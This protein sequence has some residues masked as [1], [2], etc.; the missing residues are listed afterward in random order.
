M[1]FSVSSQILQDRRISY[2]V[3]DQTLRIIELHDTA[4][5]FPIG[6]PKTIVGA[7]LLD[8]VPELIG[9]ESVLDDILRGT[10]PRFELAWVNL[11]LAQDQTR[12]LTLVVL[13]NRDHVGN[14]SGLIHLVQDV[15]ELGKIHQQ[16]AQQR[17]E[18]RLLRDQ[19]S[20]QNL[21]LSTA[22][23][24]LRRLDEMKSVF[25]SVATHELQTPLSSIIGFIEMLLDEDYDPLTSTQREYLEIIQDSS[26]RLMTIIKDLLDMTRIEAGRI[27][28]RLRPT[29]LPRLLN[30]VVSEFRPQLEAKAQQVSL[31]TILDPPFALCDEVRAMQIVGNLLSNA[32]KYTP[33]GGGIRITMTLTE[34][35][36]V[37]CVAV[38]DTGVGISAEDQIGLFKR[39]YRATNAAVTGASGTG[40]GLYITRSLVELHGGRIWLESHLGQGSTFYVT[41]PIAGRLTAS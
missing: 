20:D 21:E 7:S 13:P 36:R 16:V 1:S 11:E 31:S 9:S 6:I 5:V 19:L 30:E 37:L 15:T 40:L 29:D 35:D 41:F 2:L 28:L 8:H 14:I 34:P 12:Y 26:D 33:V 39:F 23:A 38:A 17:N 18:L 3:T 24:E 10:V 27:E 32:G 22:N 25:V 4:R